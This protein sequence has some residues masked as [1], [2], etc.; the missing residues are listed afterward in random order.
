MKDVRE[1]YAG[2]TDEDLDDDV[3]IR[4]QGKDLK[5]ETERDMD[6]LATD[7]YEMIYGSDTSLDLDSILQVCVEN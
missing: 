7:I 6:S 2:V 5:S 3:E 1:K 4:R